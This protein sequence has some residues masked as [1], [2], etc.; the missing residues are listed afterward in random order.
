MRCDAPTEKFAARRRS[1]T[2][3]STHRERAFGGRS[4]IIGGN[5]D[6]PGAPVEAPEVVS[7]EVSAV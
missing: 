1:V 3:P 7:S 4:P 5:R 2:G 6:G